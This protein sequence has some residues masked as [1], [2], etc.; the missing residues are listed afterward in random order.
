MSQYSKLLLNQVGTQHLEILKG[1][2]IDKK[3]VTFYTKY[4]YLNHSNVIIVCT[5]CLFVLSIPYN[6]NRHKA[7]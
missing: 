2:V 1:V 6:L 5:L 3:S 4:T 7:V